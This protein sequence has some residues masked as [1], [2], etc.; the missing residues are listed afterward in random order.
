MYVLVSPSSI[1][2]KVSHIWTEG[3]CEHCLLIKHALVNACTLS[4]NFQILR[5]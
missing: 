3:T 4:D 2:P 1:N 5:K